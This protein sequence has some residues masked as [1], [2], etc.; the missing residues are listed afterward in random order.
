ME[1]IMSYKRKIAALAIVV[2]C[3]A[4]SAASATPTWPAKILGTWKGVSNQTSVVLRVTSQTGAGKCQDIVGTLQN[5]RGATDSIYGYYCPS[6]GAIEFRRFG[7]G[8]SA[9]YQAYTGSLN[10]NYAGAPH[11]LIAGTFSQYNPSYGPLGQY[12]FSFIN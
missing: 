8:A 6:S 9:A 11:L 10:Q 3:T 1:N 4:A 5:V 12:S 2:A 7:S